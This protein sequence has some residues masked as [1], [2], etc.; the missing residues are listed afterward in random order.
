MSCNPKLARNLLSKIA[1]GPLRDR[2]AS[3]ENIVTST[4]HDN[5]TTIEPRNRRSSE[6][7]RQLAYEQRVARLKAMKKLQ[8]EELDTLRSRGIVQKRLLDRRMRSKAHH[9]FNNR[10]YVNPNSSQGRTKK[11]SILVTGEEQDNT[12]SAE[13][14][15]QESQIYIDNF[16]RTPSK[17]QRVLQR[18]NSTQ[19]S[20]IKNTEIKKA[21][22]KKFQFASLDRQVEPEVEKDAIKSQ[23]DTSIGMHT[24]KKDSKLSNLKKKLMASLHKKKNQEEKPSSPSKL[25]NLSRKIKGGITKTGK[26]KSRLNRHPSSSLD[27]LTYLDDVRVKPRKKSAERR[28]LY[29]TQKQSVKALEDQVTDVSCIK[30]TL[31][32]PSS[33]SAPAKQPPQ[34]TSPPGSSVNWPPLSSSTASHDMSLQ[35]FG[36]PYNSEVAGG[37]PMPPSKQSSSLVKDSFI[38]D[39][40]SQEETNGVL[41]H[42]DHMM[43]FSPPI[44]KLRDIEQNDEDGYISESESGTYSD[45]DEPKAKPTPRIAA[46][47]GGDF[48]VIKT[49]SLI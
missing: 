2:N 1:T 17:N 13:F 46:D 35:S 30:R 42:D 27:E 16:F 15:R 10:L 18:L 29:S 7:R 37:P 21:S 44:T 3:P 28:K 26:R 32:I 36:M 41:S 22:V 31:P 38:N 45:D 4:A 11:S 40:D 39:G 48:L 19:I 8:N 43:S 49:M 5:P 9:L 33:S 24:K 25:S 12:P 23:K 14:I 47:G 20:G 34:L 6:E